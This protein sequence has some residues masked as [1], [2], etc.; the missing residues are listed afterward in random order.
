MIVHHLGLA[1]GGRPAATFAQRLMMPVSNDTLLRVVRRRSQALAEALIV[2]GI[3]D[4][5]WKHNHRYGTIV[6]DLERRPTVQLLPDREQATSHDWLTTH[7]S[8]RIV[9]RDRSGGYGEAAV[10]ALPDARQIADRWHPMENG[11]RAF[12]DSVQKIHAPHSL[13]HRL[14]HD[15]SQAPDPSRAVAIW[16]LSPPP[17]DQ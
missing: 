1:L 14:Q 9:A 11:S 3:D 6:C 13:G 2:I 5:A 10:K 15:R 8:I 7:P 4:F 12:L 17:R 16:R